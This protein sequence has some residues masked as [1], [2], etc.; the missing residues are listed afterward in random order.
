MEPSLNVTILEELIHQILPERPLLTSKEAGW[1]NIFLAY[2]QHPGSEICE[3]TV[4]FHVLEVIDTN[5][6]SAHSR[7]LGDKLLT[8]EIS[9]GET[10]LCP[11]NTN[12]W[13]SWKEKLGFTLLV[14]DPLFFKQLARETE[15][16]DC[17]QIEF[18]PQW[19]V[20]DPVI[21]TITNA[22]RA[23]LEAGCPA[24]RL[25]GESFGTALIT[26]LMKRFLTSKCT[27]FEPFEGLPKH[28][29]KQ[30]LEHIQAHLAEDIALEDLAKVA[31]IS[32]FYF[33]RLFKQSMR[34]TP[35]QYVIRQ[36]IEL[37]KQL[38]KQTDY[39]VTD[40]AL[41]CGFAHPT[42]LSRHFHRL[43]GISPRA[44]RKQ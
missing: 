30:V 15:A 26:H 2:Y 24:G 11:A 29:L 31:G 36:R 22:L 16:L 38:L 39:N 40:V 18:I 13:T 19:K 33:A 25:Y 4:P 27:T 3:H 14:F 23:D 20:F 21:Q 8:Y 35:H 44:F 9:G 37:A 28:K 5:S 6:R 42:H 43:V 10:F 32:Q 7:R 12:H 1:K 34:I 17:N 41:L